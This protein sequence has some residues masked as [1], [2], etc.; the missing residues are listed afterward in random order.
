[1]RFNSIIAAGLLAA[2]A[3]SAEAAR[4]FAPNYTFPDGSRGFALSTPGDID[5]CWFVEFNLRSPAAGYVAPSLFEADGSVT[6]LLPAGAPADS[7]YT[8]G[9]SFLEVGHPRLATPA[10]PNADGVTGL[11]FT[12][13]ADDHSRFHVGLTVQGDGSVIKWSE[14]NPFTPAPG[15]FFGVQFGFAAAGDPQVRL[16]IFKDGAPLD[17]GLSPSVP[18]PGTWTLM[19]LGLGAV[20][21]AT[22]RRIVYQ[23]GRA[24]TAR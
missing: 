2:A 22:R 24:A 3:T 8:F 13:L 12:S 20:G 14:F 5:P 15:D 6:I 17:L 1:M 23:S 21:A 4:V 18:E 16:G 10:A 19:L 11:D 7:L 9:M